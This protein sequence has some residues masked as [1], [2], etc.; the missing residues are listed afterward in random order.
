MKK[1]L[2]L[3][4]A[5]VLALSLFGCTGAREPARIAAT[6][7]P[8]YDFTRYLCRGT[9]LSVTLLV[10]QNVSCLHDFSLQASQMQA[11]EQAELVVLSGAGLEEFLGDALR[12]KPAADASRGLSLLEGHSH[13]HDAHPEESPGH[14]HAQDPH[15]WLSPENAKVMADN[16]CAG[17]CDRFPAYRQTFEANLRELCG[18]LD[19]L[20]AY[21]D[22]AL[23][24]LR[25]RELITFHD[26]FSYLA[27]AFDLTVLEA[28]EEESGSEASAQTLIGLIRLVQ[29][30]DLPAIFTEANGSQAAASII[31]GE[32]GTKVFVLDMAISGDSYFQAM[33]RNIDTIREALQ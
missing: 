9:G 28:V 16:I 27:E 6:T 19:A 15:I 24:D 11:L 26:G 1:L 18:E 32:T 12:G 20:Q 3:I 23:K 30:H 8:V 5:G 21:G 29:S 33:Y 10:T 22:Q 2:S 7:L 4:L 25:C 13:N 17:L 31:A 14:I